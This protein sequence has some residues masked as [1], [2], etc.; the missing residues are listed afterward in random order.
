MFIGLFLDRLFIS[1][2]E[3][4]YEY[5][6]KVENTTSNNRIA[7]QHFFL[8]NGRWWLSRYAFP[9]LP[10]QS[11]FRYIYKYEG[12]LILDTFRQPKVVHYVFYPS[13]TDQTADPLV[14]WFSGSPGCSSLMGSFYENGPFKFVP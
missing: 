1:I 9:W 7:C 10:S 6:S 14:L 2:I 8:S 3:I 12:F 11:L 13:Q 5:P 4:Y